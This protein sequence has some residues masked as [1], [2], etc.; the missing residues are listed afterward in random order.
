MLK[1]PIEL[2]LC[3]IVHVVCLS[4]AAAV[5]GDCTGCLLCE[6][7][8]QA[9]MIHTCQIGCTVGMLRTHLWGDIPHMG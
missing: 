4:R 5:L 1:F 7:V 2:Q 8:C 9:A 3:Q 6:L